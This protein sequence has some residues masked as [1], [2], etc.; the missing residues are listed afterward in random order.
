MKNVVR[1]AVERTGGRGTGARGGFTLIE[2]LVVIAII[3]ILAAILFPVFG[4]ARENA[5]RASCQSNLKQ[6]GLGLMQYAQDNNE[7]VA[8]ACKP[9]GST[10]DNQDP[11][12]MGVIQPFV[13]SVEIFECPSADFEGSAWIPADAHPTIWGGAKGQSFSGPNGAGSYAMNAFNDPGS[14]AGAGTNTNDAA[15]G[16]RG[17][18]TPSQLHTGMKL[19]S[20]QD[21]AK[22]IWVGDGN[23]GSPWFRAV[24]AVPAVGA[25]DGNGY[26]FIGTNPATGASGAFIERHLGTSVFLF[27]DGHVKSLGLDKVT[28]PMLTVKAD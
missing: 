20:I 14:N 23:G 3:A 11:V 19:S 4:R 27:A 2:L 9:N 16:L 25:D 6:M 28:L 15:L 10:C 26:R 1:R 8:V 12:W 18:G 13:K 24:G 5:R 21:P 7:R 22:T 17:P